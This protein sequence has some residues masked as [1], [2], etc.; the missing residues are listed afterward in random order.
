MVGVDSIIT[1][2]IEVIPPSQ[3]SL[4]QTGTMQIGVTSS[5]ITVTATAL[6]GATFPTSVGFGG[7]AITTTNLVATPTFTKSVNDS[8][9]GT[10]S[11]K[12]G[13]SPQAGTYTFFLT[14]GASTPATISST[15]NITILPQKAL[16]ATIS[17]NLRIG[18]SATANITVT[19]LN[20]ATIT[21]GS[22]VNIASVGTNLKFGVFNS[23]GVSQVSLGEAPTAAAYPIT[24]TATSTEVLSTTVTVQIIDEAKVS[25]AS[26][27][28]LQIGDA[29]SA[30]TI[31]ATTANYTAV[32]T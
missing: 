30:V 10:V 17:A 25:V 3:I 6:Y 19:G 8:A 20:G 31:T 13:T 27:G 4:E 24:I 32:P 23:S 26:S 2:D 21:S 22:L 9:I 18:S 5:A 28:T 12:F 11:L 7:T 29:D 16:K 14:D 1:I 15:I